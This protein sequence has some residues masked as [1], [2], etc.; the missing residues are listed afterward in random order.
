MKNLKQAEEYISPQIETLELS[1]ER[2]FTASLTS[3]NVF[4]FSE[5]G[6]LL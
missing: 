1:V 2:G 4:D 5:G 3:G 6:E